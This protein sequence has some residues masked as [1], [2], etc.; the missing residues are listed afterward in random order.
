M[1][2]GLTHPN[3]LGPIETFA[4]TVVPLGSALGPTVRGAMPPLCSSNR[5]R[6]R[7]SG[8]ID[9]V[10]RLPFDTSAS[11]FAEALGA[12][13]ETCDGEVARCAAL[14]ICHPPAMMPSAI[15]I[16]CETELSNTSANLSSR[17]AV[18]TA[19][20]TLLPLAELVA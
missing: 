14:V 8:A 19:S 4:L 6:D 18:A 13:V 7:G 16:E 1:V 15:P 9:A 12:A 3:A 11:G 5:P 17:V 10:A 20:L 2:I